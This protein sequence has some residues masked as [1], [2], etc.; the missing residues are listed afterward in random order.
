M[1]FSIRDLLL[2][3]VIVATCLAWAIDH[4]RQASEIKTLRE[5]PMVVDFSWIGPPNSPAPAP[6]SPG[7][8][9]S[10]PKFAW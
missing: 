6:K 8:S 10:V 1:S 4:L 3:T 7:K 5:Q 9:A 2:M